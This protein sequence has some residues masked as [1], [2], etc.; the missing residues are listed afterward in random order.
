MFVKELKLFNHDFGYWQQMKEH[1]IILTNLTWRDFCSCML[2]CYC[3]IYVIIIYN[4]FFRHGVGNKISSTRKINNC[5]LSRS[6]CAKLKFFMFAAKFLK[7]TP[8]LKYTCKTSQCNKYRK[9]WTM[10][11]VK[12]AQSWE[13][14]LLID[15]NCIHKNIK[16]QMTIY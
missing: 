11:C 14:V 6:A 4:Y 5:V 16:L 3:C 1:L 10:D 8:A 13:A 7:W 9:L 15:P 2:P 12:F